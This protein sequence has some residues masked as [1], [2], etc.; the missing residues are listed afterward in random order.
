MSPETCRPGNRLHAGRAYGGLQRFERPPL[1]G[2]LRPQ[3]P[4]DSLPARPIPR[5]KRFST[6]AA[7]SAGS[8]IGRLCLASAIFIAAV[9]ELD[10][11]RPTSKTLVASL[12]FAIS[13]I[14][15]VG[16]AG[17]AEIY[18]N[19]LGQ[20][21]PISPGGVRPAAR[22]GGRARHE[23]RRHLPFAALYI[24]VIATASLLVPVGGGL[25]IA[26]LGNVV[27]LRRRRPGSSALAAHEPGVWL[28]LAVFAL[29]ALGMR[30]S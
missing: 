12:A 1:S 18:R 3:T 9:A 2:S 25:L 23:R 16:S 30:V 7:S 29:V 24:L 20:R 6:R 11:G 10:L 15:T 21:L 14:V 28:Q 8:Y 17:Y 22:H 4:C 27:L 5:S 26:A 19:R 13:P